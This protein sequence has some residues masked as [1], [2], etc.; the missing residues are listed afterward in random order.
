MRCDSAALLPEF[1]DITYAYRFGPPLHEVTVASL[2]DAEDATLIADAFHFPAGHKLPQRDLGL[3]ARVERVADA[4]YL[5]IRARAFAQFVHVED[6][7]F[8]AEDDWLHLAPGAE[9][10]IRLRPL[11]NPPSRTD[12]VPS[13]EI[14]ALNMDRVV[15]YARPR[16]IPL[17]ISGCFGVL[18]PADAPQPADGP[19]GV[20][21]CGSL[22]DE[23][24]NVYRPLVFLAE[25]FAAAGSPTLRL[26]YYGT[27]DS[28][29][30][31]GEPGR[32][33]AWLAGVASGVRWL[34]ET[35]GVG[36]VTLVGVR[37]GAALAARAAC[38]IDDV[39]A[40]ILLSPVPDGRRFVRELI[41]RARTIAEIWQLESR[42]EQGGWSEA[43][44]L[45]LDRPTRDALERLDVAELPRC[46]APRALVLDDPD[47]PA[48]GVLAERLRRA[49][50]DVTC[51]SA[52]G[53]GSCC[54]MPTKTRR[55]TACS[56]APS[57]GTQTRGPQSPAMYHRPADTSRADALPGERNAS[58][59]RAG[60]IART[61]AH[62]CNA[63]DA[64]ATLVTDHGSETPICF[65]PNG[66]LFGILS[67][68]AH[69]REHAPPV[70][71]ASTGANPRY[72]NSRVAVGVA[73]WLA[74][75]GIASLRMDG[76]G[77]GDSAIET[78]ERG[79]PYS[80]PRRQRP[81]RGD[82]RTQPPVRHIGARCSACARVR[83]TPC[84]PPTKIA[85]L[86]A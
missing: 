70:L 21:I 13:G 32:F 49:G 18:H 60:P 33:Q 17:Y 63:G 71:I 1:F 55:R 31:D 78:G 52:D 61:L 58:C 27:G 86:P 36:K 29:G 5:A 73:R 47:S 24:L 83:S 40:L 65:G 25:Q 20:L 15:R 56:P 22:G 12:A 30:E 4:W 34:R 48:G 64:T 79:Q 72:G 45:R 50:T 62:A 68:P 10:R 16:M 80:Q 67:L 41:L 84:A 19:R 57:P 51:E 44:G 85:A 42:I 7:A 2:H 8:V 39:E 53:M 38:E 28:G 11:G 66:R 43:H 46:P 6:A 54:A 23:A 35:C 69:P 59:Q 75:N 3:E 9:R 14:R 77:I 81:H 37:I 76:A 26:Q 74:A 82:R